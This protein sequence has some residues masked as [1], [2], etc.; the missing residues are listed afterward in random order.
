MKVP[1]A[2]MSVLNGTFVACGG[3]G[4]RPASGPSNVSNGTF[5]TSA[6]N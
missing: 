5:V 2:T 6:T 1:F 4:E 3:R